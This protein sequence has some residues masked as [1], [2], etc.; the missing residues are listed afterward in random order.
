MVVPFA[1]RGMAFANGQGIVAC[2]LFPVN[3]HSHSHSLKF[4]WGGGSITPVTIFPQK[5]TPTHTVTEIRC[6]CSGG[7]KGWGLIFT[8]SFKKK[9]LILERL[10]HLQNGA[11]C[12]SASDDKKQ[13]CALVQISWE[14]V[15]KFIFLDIIFL[16][17]SIA[18]SYLI[19]VSGTMVHSPTNCAP[20]RVVSS[21]ACCVLL[22]SQHWRCGVLPQGAMP[23]ELLLGE[24]R[25][26]LLNSEGSSGNGQKNRMTLS[27][28]AMR[29]GW[30][31][32]VNEIDW[33]RVVQCGVRCH[34]DALRHGCS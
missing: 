14:N 11:N 4:P 31:V 3:F 16:D 25:N 13:I 30:R 1:I 12:L 19:D 18:D 9:T 15:Q 7:G 29:D 21:K 28:D 23:C 5:K 24:D 27:V 20:Q 26:S 22:T 34:V 33:P 17:I 10:E 2:L 8:I 6:R 32:T